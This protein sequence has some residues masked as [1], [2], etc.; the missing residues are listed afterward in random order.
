MKFGDLW[1][2]LE[3]LSETQIDSVYKAASSDKRYRLELSGLFAVCLLVLTVFS[4]SVPAFYRTYHSMLTT[5]LI[6]AA[7]GLG[8][9]WLVV[10]ALMRINRWLYDRAIMRVLRKLGLAG[11]R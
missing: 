9:I 6:L 7:G 3:P 5:R 1:P 4:F 2:Y 8:L 10:G 11:G